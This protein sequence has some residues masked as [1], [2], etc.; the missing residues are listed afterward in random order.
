[1]IHGA[2]SAEDLAGI[3]AFVDQHHTPSLKTGTWLGHVETHRYGSG[4]DGI[5]FQNIIE[6]GAVFERC[7]DHPAWIDRV[8]RYIE[9]EA[10]RVIIDENFLNVRQSGGYI[11]V[12]SGGSHVRFTSCFRNHAGKWMVGQIN[13]LMALTDIGLGDGCTTVVPGS[14]KS[15]MD[16]PAYQDGRGYSD[17]RSGGEA[18]GMVQVHLKAGDALMFTDAITHGSIPRTNPGERRVMIYRYAPHLLAT[19]YNYLPSDGLL[20]RLGPRARQMVM[21]QP[22][23]FHPDRTLRFT[24]DDG[25]TDARV[26]RD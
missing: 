16:H 19:R 4:S 1:M 13:V 5:N 10:H 15:H 7:I 9:V 14:H 11:P 22:P 3:N 26:A 24:A 23:R 8:R 25:P 2:L 6:G 21:A 18:V 20:A 12:H 17:S